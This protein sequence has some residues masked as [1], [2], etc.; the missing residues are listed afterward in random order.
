MEPTANTPILQWKP[1]AGRVLEAALNRL[2]ALDQATQMQLRRLDARRIVLSLEAPAL[3]LELRVDGDQLRV[4]PVQD[5]E[6]DLGIRSNLSGLL[7]QLPFLRNTDSSPVGKLRI[8]GDAELARRLQ[9]LAS[10]FNPQ[11]QQVFVE[12]FGEIIG[13]QIAKL[14]TD[15]LRYAKYQS[16]EFAHNAAEFITEEAQLI[17]SKAELNA[18]ND[19]VDSIRDRVE[20][21]IARINQLQTPDSP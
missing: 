18:F 13:P 2:L 11:F 3:S 21:L 12:V 19:D 17:V 7:A 14:F 20:R 1:H 8:N 16:A 6:P 4:G 9:Q 5:A 10:Q 15:A